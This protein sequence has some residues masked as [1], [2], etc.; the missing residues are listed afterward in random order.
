DEC[1]GPLK[2]TVRRMDNPKCPGDDATAFGP[3]VPFFCCDVNNG[4]VMVVLHV[5]DASG[6]F[7]ECMVEAQV[8]DKLKPTI[9]CPADLTIQCGEPTSPTDPATYSITK[10][11]NVDISPI[12][13]N[14]YVDTLNVTGLPSNAKIT[15]LNL[16]LDLKHEYI[17]QLTIKLISPA[18]T[19][20]T[21]FQGGSCGQF[22]KDINAI[23]DDQGVAFYC[24]GANPAISGNVKPQVSQMSYVNGEN[25]NGKWKLQ[26]YDNA[27]LGGGKI[28]SFKLYFNYATPIAIK[29]IVGDNTS[30]CGLIV[31]WTDLNLPGQC[32]GNSFI[33]RQWSAT[34]LSGNSKTCIQKINLVDNTPLDVDFPDDVTIYDCTA[35][36]S[37]TG[38]EAIKHTGDCEIVAIEFIDEVFNVVPDA[39]YKIIRTWKVLDWC[40][41]DPAAPHTDGGIDVDFKKFDFNP[42]DDVKNNESDTNHKIL[43]DDGDGYFSIKQVIK[44]IDTIPPKFDACPQNLTIC[45]FATDCANNPI[46][47]VRPATDACAPANK[48]KY[49]WKLDVGDNGN[50]DLSGKGDSLI[51]IVP[52]GKH[53]AWFR[54]EDGCGNYDIC[55]FDFTVQ[56]CKKPTPVCINGLS[57]DIMLSGMVSIWAK[58]FNASSTDNCT[59]ADKLKFS[60]SADTTDKNIIYTCDSLGSR[61]VTVWVTDEAGNQDFCT[62]FILI[63]DNMGVCN[64]TIGMKNV[65]G[66]IVTEKG[67]KVGEVQVALA[68][69][70]APLFT[71]NANGTYTFPAMSPGGNYTIVPVKD[72]DPLN[73]VS[74]IDLVNITNHILGKKALDGPYKIIAADANNNGTV[75][76]GDLSEIRKLILHINAKFPKTTSWRFIDKNFKF[77]D[78][79][80]PWKTTFPEVYNISNLNNNM[81]IDFVAIKV[82]DVTGDVKASAAAK[83]E[84]R[85]NA[86]TLSFVLDDLSMQKGLTYKLAV[87]AKDFTNT[88]G[89]QYTLDFNT[90]ALEFVSAEGAELSG[91]SDENFG[92]THLEEGMITSSWNGP[93]T[94]VT[95]GTTLFV[96]TFK[97]KSDIKLSKALQIGSDLTPAEAYNKDAEMMEVQMQFNN[98]KGQVA[99]S[100]ELLQN[101]P[102]PFNEFTNIGFNLAADEYAQLVITD[103]AGKVVKLVDGE[104]AKGFNQVKISKS[105]IGSSGIYYY[106]LN[107]A[108]ASQTKK[109]II[110]E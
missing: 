89:Y 75:T 40:R 108:E 22:K 94:T 3:Q 66:I 14:T 68:G 86:G 110:I 55:E 53:H 104:F 54:V 80:N 44:I 52:L 18:G 35:L 95:D 47:I 62:T 29:P 97:A 72:I 39:C 79:K 38:L 87:K 24:N 88:I 1:G 90:D 70:T 33:S 56:D 71:T 82:G 32:L 101:I 36:D 23:F 107:T 58:D 103:M 84:V 81:T 5:E 13:A 83:N 16:G 28:N 4:P 6:N 57:T 98:E 31:T 46:L 69:S 34:D 74:T 96:L 93:V 92:L 20:L 49:S 78:P 8:V 76:T 11:S 50:Y 73:G 19:V 64:D 12:F 105:D 106:Q 65:S 67:A 26:V 37:L 60:F 7:N 85:N 10:T 30:D 17:D 48:L 9:I 51:A 43:R 102:N 27:P 42:N 91:I 59:S 25:P 63:T 100:F 2:L 41:Y 109:M 77:T 99:G 21:L 15:D 61:T 45:S